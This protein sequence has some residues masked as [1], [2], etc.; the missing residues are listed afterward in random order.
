MKGP[1]DGQV[2]RGKRAAA[3]GGRPD[4]NKFLKLTQEHK[5]RE[6]SSREPQQE[7]A[8]ILLQ[9][10]HAPKVAPFEGASSS[11]TECD[12][13]DGGA[14]QPEAQGRGLEATR[15]D[16]SN[17]SQEAAA[18]CDAGAGALRSGAMLDS[19]WDND[20]TELEDNPSDVLAAIQLLHSQF[21]KVR[22]VSYFLTDFTTVAL[23]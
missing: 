13:Q 17:H 23:N 19:G 11:N 5:A 22:K 14:E 20:T 15:D 10:L 7:A 12:R 2:R 1:S 9:N 16:P 3:G 18:C 6:R 21:P 4:L 8:R